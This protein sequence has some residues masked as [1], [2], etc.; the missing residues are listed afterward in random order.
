MNT[1]SDQSTLYSL[2][3]NYMAAMGTSRTTLVALKSYMD[4]VMRLRCAEADFRQLLM[5]LNTV[6]KNTQPKVMP[7]VHLIE[8]F[9]A[10]MAPHF[11]A[12]LATAKNKAIDILSQKLKLF[13]ADTERLTLNCVQ[14]IQP[15]DFI[16]AHSPTAYI[17]HAFVRAFTDKRRKFK[18][19]VLKQD[20]IRTRQLVNTLE[21]YEVEHLVVPEYN[22]SHYLGDV[23]K[24][25][26]GAVSLSADRKAVT[27]IGTANVV[28]LCHVH[29][30]PVYLFAESIK[31][32]H[33]SLPEQQIYKEEQQKVESDYT[34]R[35]TTFS[36]D[37]VDLSQVDHIVTENGEYRDTSQNGG[38]ASR[39]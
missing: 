5:E 10:E 6:I 24:L 23:N 22:L 25:F 29:K 27:G 30:I 33:T 36:H 7:L 13:E 17:R 3:R 28:G 20:F 19:L 4:A 21:R 2:I 9:E 34:F 37:I 15:G 31:F 12:D 38:D 1:S 11:K 14:C 32:A 18:V 35:L 39:S 26:I 8:A 16:I